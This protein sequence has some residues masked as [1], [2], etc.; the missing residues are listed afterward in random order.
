MISATLILLSIFVFA[1]AI[2][3]I[4]TAL[5]IISYLFSTK[6]SSSFLSSHKAF[7]PLL[8]A[9]ILISINLTYLMVVNHNLNLKD[10]FGFSNPLFIVLYICALYFFLSKDEKYANYLLNVFLC[11]VGVFAI[12]FTTIFIYKNIHGIGFIISDLYTGKSG[13][14]YIQSMVGLTF[15]LSAVIILV[16]SI[17]T[18]YKIS[19][20]LLI[21]VAL[22][23]M[24]ADIFVN[25]GKIGYF[26][27]LS[28][29]FYYSFIFV[30]KFSYSD[31]KLHIIKSLL[32]MF[33]S[34]IF[35]LMLFGLAYNYSTTFNA[36]MSDMNKSISSYVTS[37][38]SMANSQYLWS[39]STG[40]R[41]M[42]YSTSLKIFKEYPSV[43]LFGCG[44]KEG[45]KDITECSRILIKKSSKLKN[46]NYVVQ[47][48]VE[49]HN[50]FINYVFKAGI[51][52]SICLVMFFIML[53][54][55]A[56]NLSYHNMVFLRLLVIGFVIGSLFEYFIS[57]QMS[58]V[59]F[60][61]LIA[62]F[63][64]KPLDHKS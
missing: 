7:I 9:G 29:L 3:S 52:A 61:T 37:K 50:E 6:G 12:V 5:I 26:I 55:D 1:R 21:L 38:P 51:G 19:R 40:Q 43:F 36:R 14:G 20:V 24:F 18:K 58:V 64:A 25:R 23:I 42:Y 13:G 32:A 59:I 39:T 47:T 41:F 34:I 48:G 49:P 16:K 2:I 63:L 4:G 46:D 45:I 10:I 54:R 44:Y 30:K 28:V 22:V 57:S 53:F 35:I 60:A 31:G 17:N 11:V 8:I 62:I 56:R 27:E 15:P 33:S